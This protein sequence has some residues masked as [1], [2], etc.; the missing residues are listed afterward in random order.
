MCK[1][2]QDELERQKKVLQETQQQHDHAEKDSQQAGIEQHPDDKTSIISDSHKQAGQPTCES[3][4]LAAATSSPPPTASALAK[5]SSPLTFQHTV[6]PL[7]TLTAPSLRK[8]DTVTPPLPANLHIPSPPPSHANSA[9]DHAHTHPTHQDTD[10]A[11]ALDTQS[12]SEATAESIRLDAEWQELQ[13]KLGDCFCQVVVNA[14]EVSAVHGDRSAVLPRHSAA[15]VDAA[16][17]GGAAAAEQQAPIGLY[18]YTDAKLFAE[19]ESVFF[20]GARF[21]GVCL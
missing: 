21:G 7:S 17:A 10:Q 14:L 8:P 12:M 19:V 11:G 16:G 3:P 18:R 1:Q 9:A 15:G 20:P 2:Q 13:E 4:T 6:D 5:P